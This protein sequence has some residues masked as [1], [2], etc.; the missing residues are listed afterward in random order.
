MQQYNSDF[1]FSSLAPE[2]IIDGL[3]DAGFMV[4]SGLL[5]LN[6]YENRVYQFHDMERHK[7][8]CKFYRPGRWQLSQIQEEHDFAF[9]LQEHELPIVAPLKRDG[10]S[11]FH[12]QGFLFAVFPCRGGRIFE[13][14]NLEQLEWMG[15]FV[16]RIHAVSSQQ[17]FQYRPTISIQESLLDA[18]Q[19]LMDCQMV[20]LSLQTPFFTVLEQAIDL[21][22]ARYL[23]Q[24]QIRLHGDCHAGNILWT[25]D[26]PHFVDLDDCRTGPAIQ[27]LWM[28][29]SGDRSQ[30]LVQ[31]DTLLSGYEEFFSFDNSELS[32]IESLRTMRVVHYMAWLARRWQDPAFPRNFPWFDTEKYWEQQI[33]ALKEQVAALQEPPLSLMP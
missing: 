2:T 30:Q 18:R 22:A 7:F 32:L 11:I 21:A 25:D 6:S 16:G 9:Q 17:S 5:A 20:P 27:D 3:E 26:G 23:P 10:H 33:L 19:V 4:D 14:D 15:R 8:V 31:L 29:L 1:N 13:V 28:M 12:H 24:T